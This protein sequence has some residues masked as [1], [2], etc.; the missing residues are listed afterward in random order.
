MIAFASR[1]TL[2]LSTA[3]LVF[4]AV[5]AF[6]DETEGQEVEAAA[7]AVSEEKR[8]EKAKREWSSLPRK[9]RVAR[10]WRSLPKAERVAREKRGLRP[11]ILD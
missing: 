8:T 7:P 3:G 9:E 10:E 6:A 4:A 5:P 11:E 1:L 2:V